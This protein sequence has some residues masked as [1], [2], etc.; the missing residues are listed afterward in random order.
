MLEAL[1]VPMS[2]AISPDG[3]HIATHQD[4]RIRIWPAFPDT[5]ELID[6][7]RR[8]VMPR[9]STPAAQV[10]F[11]LEGIRRDHGPSAQ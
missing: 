9:G 5:R 6:R 4:G 3:T 7:A 8:S 1:A 2:D 11:S 10:T